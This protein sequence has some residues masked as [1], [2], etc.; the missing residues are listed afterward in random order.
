MGIFGL[1]DEADA[2][3]GPTAPVREIVTYLE[4]P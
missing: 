1:L 4:H 3:R 2:L